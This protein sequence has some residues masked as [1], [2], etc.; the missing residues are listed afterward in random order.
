MV[1]VFLTRSIHK[2]LKRKVLTLYPVENVK[3]PRENCMAMLAQISFP[4]ETFRCS[5]RHWI[6]SNRFEK[7]IKTTFHF[8]NNLIIM[9]VWKYLP[10]LQTQT[11]SVIYLQ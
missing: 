7:K 8:L 5:L 9:E 2:I 10:Y 3:W 6:F 11:I 1:T 4:W